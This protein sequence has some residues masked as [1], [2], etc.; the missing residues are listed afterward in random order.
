MADRDLP[1]SRLR[2]QLAGPRGYKRIDALL[3]EE[4]APAAIA[5]LAP[6]EIYELVH[7]VGFEDAQPLLEL[8]TP[9]Q[10]QG[11]ID[12]DGW[13]RDE[14]DVS[15]IHPWL[16][17]LIET[18]FEK[19]AEV[20]AGLDSEL[21]ALIFQRDFKVYDATLGEEPPEDDEHSILATPDRF[22][23]LEL[24][25]EPNAQSL[26]QRFVEDLYRGDADLARHT[27][28]SARS[29]PPAELE[30]M[31]YRWRSGRLADQGY[32]DFYDALDLFRP[33]ELDQVAIGE[34][35]QDPITDGTPLALTVLEELVGRS[36]LAR[37]LAGM[38]QP[39]EAE[40]IEHA[41]TALVNKVLAAGRAK[42]GQTEV[43][44]RGALYATSTIALGLEAVSRGDLGRATAALRSIGLGRLFRVGHTVAL[45]LAR[46]AQALAPRSLTAGSPAKELVAALVSPRPLF[47]RAADDPPMPGMRPFESQADLRRAGE[48]LTA[49]TLRIALVESLGVDVAAMGRAPEPRPELDDHLR[50]ALARAVV[51]GEFRG[52][53]LTAAELRELRTR[54]FSGAKLT[55]AARA[56]GHDA[57]VTRLGAAQLTASTLVLSRAIDGWLDDLE[58][59][60]GS[61]PPDEEVDPRF[62]EGVLVDV[63][64][65]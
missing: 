41:L 16:A 20:W 2:A 30:E 17:S 9:A 51:G 57:I 49:L 46:L 1:L 47:A 18:G 54:G 29:E 21:R 12:L 33:L 58:A 36:F 60:L 63:K 52:D 11:C 32:V 10:I 50:T 40:G 62:V 28:M 27:I 35:S 8:A 13:T 65:S 5:A 26:A 55:P 25:D 37:A 6:N 53:A 19:V 7:E 44:R 34:G 56:A 22:F 4:D 59:L 48:I 24:P 39:G 61:I 45:K 42:P 15:Q 23:M 31:S 43:M 64:R 38:D 14:L 3:S